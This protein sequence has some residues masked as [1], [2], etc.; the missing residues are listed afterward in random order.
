MVALLTAPRD[1][2]SLDLMVSS[3]SLSEQKPLLGGATEAPPGLDLVQVVRRRKPRQG[4]SG[5]R[6]RCRG[7]P[8]HAAEYRPRVPVAWEQPKWSRRG[9]QPPAACLVREYDSRPPSADLS[10]SFPM[11]GNDS[12][13]PTGNER[14]GGQAA[15]VMRRGQKGAP[16]WVV[17]RRRNARR[18][19]N[20]GLVAVQLSLFTTYPS[21]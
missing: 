3:H 4:W 6:E 15:V 9:S 8:L 10:P 20:G 5:T 18:R 19:V 12:E 14:T 7:R 2:L 17:E 13:H 1:P 11:H 16:E 21:P